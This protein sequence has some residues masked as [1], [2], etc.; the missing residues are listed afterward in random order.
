MIALW[1]GENARGHRPG[2]KTMVSKP[3]SS[4]DGS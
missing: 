3:K 2:S 1:P 4:S